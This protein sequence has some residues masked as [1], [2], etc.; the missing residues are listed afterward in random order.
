MVSISIL[1]IALTATAA[2]AAQRLFDAH[3]HYN[4]E[5]ADHYS[6]DQIIALL[7]ANDVRG[8]V[9]TSRPPE[10]L[11]PLHA[12]APA[13]IVPLLGVYRTPADKETWMDDADLPARVEQAI[14][15]GP[16]R[17]IGELHIFAAQRRNPVFLR[18]VELA[19]SQGLPLQMHCDPAVIDA[20]FEHA[21]AA[22]VIWAHAGAYPYPPLLRDYLHR[23]PG[24]HLDLSVR[25]QRI[26]PEGRLDPDWEW[27]LLEYSDRFLVGV[28]TY[29][30]ARWDD[31]AK[32]VTQIRNWLDQ[33]PAPVSEAIAY[34]NAA[35]LFGRPVED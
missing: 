26:A 35:R 17:G 18:I 21:P 24:L 8:A 2:G 3:L 23:Y 32:V 5:D 15:G 30:T 25:D 28:D 34:R 20:L 11:L 19:T 22:T 13:L 4:I 27:L 10:H 33:L 6:V 29:R 31:F 12:R 16:W 14:A 7:R 1:A 9:V